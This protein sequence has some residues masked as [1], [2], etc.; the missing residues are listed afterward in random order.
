[1]S[2]RPG[3]DVPEG[4]PAAT[5]V[6]RSRWRDPRLV[7]GIV[8][9]A[10]C[11]LLGARLLAGADGSVGVWAAR[12][13]LASGQ[14]L[15]SDDLVRREVR[16][17]AQGLA[18]RYLTADVDLP[19]GVTLGRDIGAGELVPRAALDA[20]REGALTEVPLSV[21][22]ES[23]PSTVRVG[24][25]VDVWVTPVGDVSDAHAGDRSESV[26]V[27][28]DVAVL[29]VPRSGTSLGPTATRQVIVGVGPAQEADLPTSLAT[30]TGG[31]VVLTAQR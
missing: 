28:D 10:V 27:F 2:A 14:P 16:F 5:R 9:V 12:R 20:A 24:T 1:M 15:T 8:V 6:T 29:S 30:L 31:L 25:V 7:V 11:T 18:D 21:A 23:V 13:P 26:L 22:T 19:D 3:T 17:D 4:S